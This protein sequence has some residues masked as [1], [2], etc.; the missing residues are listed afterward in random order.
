MNKLTHVSD[1]AG[2]VLPVTD[3]DVMRHDVIKHG[4]Y[5]PPNDLK[6]RF[7]HL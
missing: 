5:I 6:H 7:I 2:V 3:S 1:T 4:C